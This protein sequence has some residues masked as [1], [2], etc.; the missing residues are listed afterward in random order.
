MQRWKL[1]L[2]AIDEP[3]HRSQRDLKGLASSYAFLLVVGIL[4]WTEILPVPIAPMLLTLAAFA[5]TGLITTWVFHRWGFNSTAYRA[6]NFVETEVFLVGLVVSMEKSRADTPLLWVFY[7]LLTLVMSQVVGASFLALAFIVAPPLALNA[8]AWLHPGILTGHEMGYVFGYTVL[9]A[10]LFIFFGRSREAQL[11]LS[12][13]QLRTENELK[14]T[15]MELQTQ[16][17]LRVL[18]DDWLEVLQSMASTLVLLGKDLK[19]VDIRGND[20]L[21]GDI[22]DCLSPAFF[23]GIEQSFADA[24]EKQ[25]VISLFGKTLPGKAGF[26]DLRILALPLNERREHYALLIQDASERVALEEANKK[27]MHQLLVSDKLNS[28]GLMAAGISHEVNNPLT[29]VAGNVEY[30]L[31]AEADNDRLRVPLLDIQEGLRQITSIMG[32]LKGFSR[33]ASAGYRQSFDLRDV[34]KRATRMLS[35]EIREH[36]IFNLDL[37]DSPVFVRCHPDRIQQIIVNLLIN[38]KQALP[39]RPLAQNLIGLRLEAEDESVR[40]IVSD[41]GLGMTEEVRGK[42]FD[43]FFTTKAPGTGTGLGLSISYKIAKEHE[44]DLSVVSSPDLGSEFTLTLPRVPKPS[45]DLPI[46]I[47]DDEERLLKLYSRVLVNFTVTTAV[48]IETALPLMGQDFKAILSD[49]RLTDGSGFDLYDKAPEH[50]KRRFVFLTGFPSDTPELKDC[51]PGIQILHKPIQL[52]ELER[53]LYA[54]ATTSKAI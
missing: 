21:G 54:I 8:Y 52:D 17:K 3:Y 46:L 40:I 15:Q 22:G 28:V 16:R 24:D 50:L 48:S 35:A 43:L 32:D 41:N 26:V 14:V 39:N 51:P 27:F 34:I 25:E 33:T 30:L 18:E 4:I 5:L 9:T 11:E 6:L 13:K 19:I 2:P 47:V 7:I 29:Y 49:V 53:H 37:P 31:M 23:K 36:A 38:A 45:Y 1:K 10:G 42:I 12:T 20:L 44:G